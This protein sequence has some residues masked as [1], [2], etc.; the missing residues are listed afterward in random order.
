MSKN[1]NETVHISNVPP[2]V[3]RDAQIKAVREGRA[4][5]DILRELLEKWVYEEQQKKDR[6]QA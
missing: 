3:K 5:S 6:R 2:E 4:L 1:D